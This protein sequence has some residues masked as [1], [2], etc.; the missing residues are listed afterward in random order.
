MKGIARLRDQNVN[1]LIMGM[2]TD[3]C[4]LVLCRMCLQPL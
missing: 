2:F 3:Q 4:L 1:N